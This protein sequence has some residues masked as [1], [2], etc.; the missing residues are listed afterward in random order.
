MMLP[1]LAAIA[2]DVS[3]D[4]ESFRSTSSDEGLNASTSSGNRG[5]LDGESVSPEGLIVSMSNCIT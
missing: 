3:S 1:L 5:S 2:V 4:G